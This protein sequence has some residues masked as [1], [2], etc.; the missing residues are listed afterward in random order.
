MLKGD[1]VALRRK[2][3]LA[4]LHLAV[5]DLIHAVDVHLQGVHS[6]Q[7]LQ[8]EGHR[9]VESGDHQQE[10]K[11]GDEG[12]FA[13]DQAHA[14]YQRYRGH[15]QLQN[16]LGWNNEHGRTQFTL[17]HST[18]QHI[19]FAVQTVEI[20]PFRFVA[21]QVTDGFQAFLHAVCNGD[22]S[23]VLPAGEIVLRFLGETHN[24]QCHRQHPQGR[25]RHL[26]I[27]AKQADRYQTSRKNRTIELR[28]IVGEH[29]LRGRYVPH[30]GM[31]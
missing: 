4:A 26:P 13:A 25:D 29:L 21:F 6:R 3:R 20:C 1:V 16:H 9:F 17:D 12:Q 24:D 30:D 8:G 22:Q 7:I 5:V 10:Q 28:D 27:V 15:P 11:E 31:G 23:G 19:D 2:R 18:F 14:A